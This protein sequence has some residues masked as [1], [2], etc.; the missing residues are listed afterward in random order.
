MIA[1]NP[2]K[3][4]ATLQTIYEKTTENFSY[5]FGGKGIIII[6]YLSM[7]IDWLILK[8]DYQEKVEQ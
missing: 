8:I 7:L 2:I 5:Y 1:A 3:V 6:I 4:A